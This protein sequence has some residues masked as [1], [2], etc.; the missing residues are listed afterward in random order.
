MTSPRKLAEKV[1]DLKDDLKDNL[2][3]DVDEAMGEATDGIRTEIRSNESVASGRLIT[4]TRQTAGPQLA[5]VIYSTKITAPYP[6]TYLEYG[7]G[8]RGGSTGW[9]DDESYPSPSTLV[10]PENIQNYIEEKGITGKYYSAV[11]KSSGEPSDLAWEI[12]KS[13]TAFGT[14]A[15]P[16]M[17]PVWYGS[18]RGRDNVIGSAERA[19]NRAVRRM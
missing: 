7:T 13:I 6:Y 11:R 18:T 19:M 8:A 17:R 16:F 10:P 15:H 12:A 2:E 5:N 14:E 3:N 4:Q 9:P 1:T